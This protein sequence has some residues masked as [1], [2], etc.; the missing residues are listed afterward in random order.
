MKRFVRRALL[1]LV[2]GASLA[3]VADPAPPAA[4]SAHAAEAQRPTS[5][6]YRKDDDTGALALNV[7]FGLVVA[8]GVG[9][10]ALLLLRR[11]LGVVQRAPGRRLKVV[12]TIRLGPKSALYLVEVDQRTLLIGQQGDALAVLAVPT[13]PSATAATA[14]ATAHADHAPPTSPSASA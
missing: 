5:I 1:A 10:G 7:G 13:E 14:A 4:P 3:A 9:I 6:P 8:I 11:Y 12:E 2:L